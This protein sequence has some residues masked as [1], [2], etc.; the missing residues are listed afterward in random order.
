M[1][2]LWYGVGG[3]AIGHYYVVA[4]PPYDKLAV[5]GSSVYLALGLIPLSMFKR[6]WRLTRMLADAI[7]YTDTDRFAP[8]DSIAVRAD[9]NVH[10]EGRAKEMQLAI[11]Q[12][13]HSRSSSGGS[14]THTTTHRDLD[15]QTF[16]LDRDVVPGNSLSASTH[17][18]IPANAPATSP[19][20][21]IENPRYDYYIEVITRVSDW[22]DYVGRFAFR[23]HSATV[24]SQR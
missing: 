2:S 6:R 21:A 18:T 9:Q 1:T 4:A 17:F 20:S 7:V 14:T 15:R 12:Q 11:V 22:P 10:A 16:P 24:G 19:A 5:I 8:G 3:V 13:I 23:L